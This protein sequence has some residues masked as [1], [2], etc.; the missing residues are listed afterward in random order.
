MTKYLL[1]FCTLLFSNTRD[2]QIGIDRIYSAHTSGHWSFQ[3]GL[4]TYLTA[5]D[6]VFQKDLLSGNNSDVNQYFALSQYPALMVG[7][8]HY[9]DA[10]INLPVYTDY[11]SQSEYK[12]TGIGDFNLRTKFRIPLNQK[13]S[14]VEWALLMGIWTG[15]TVT[16]GAK[17]TRE[18]EYLRKDST[19]SPFGQKRIH[20]DFGIALTLS[21]IHI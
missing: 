3:I 9:V 20:Y 4:S 14:D 15:N 12:N 11:F 19:L 13:T 5:N 17:I 16:K 21:L 1:C 7:F 6:N 8:G 10:S 2:G 18:I